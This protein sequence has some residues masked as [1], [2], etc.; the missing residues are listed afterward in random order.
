MKK[1]LVFIFLFLLTCLV[2]IEACNC[3]C[4]ANNDNI[5]KG[6]IAVVG[7]EPFTRL[8]IQSDDNKTY[9]LQ[10]SDELKNDLWKHQGNRY[11]I[12]FSSAKKEGDTT[13][14]IIEKVIPI[15]TENKTN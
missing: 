4:G 2:L 8:A 13:I 6:Y 9:I 5:V 14:L 11:Y 1:Q 12:H 7:N 10:C 3:G 15:T